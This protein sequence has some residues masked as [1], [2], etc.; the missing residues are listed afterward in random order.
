MMIGANS[1]RSQTSC[2]EP[3]AGLDRFYSY[4]QSFSQGAEA[5]Q[6]GHYP[7]LTSRAF[8]DPDCF[9]AVRALENGYD[10]VRSELLALGCQAFH[11][12]MER[13]GRTGSWEVLHLFERGRKNDENCGL[14]PSTVR[15]I[16]SH[17]TV[18]TV[19]GLAYV[20]KMAPGTHVA[21]HC[22]PTNLRLRCHLGIQVPQGDCAIRVE[23][24]ISGWHEGKCIVFDDSLEHESWNHTA[25][26]RIVLI[27]DL[28]H[29]DLTPE[30]IALL[31]GL[32]NYSSAQAES[33][34]R[35]WIANTRARNA[36]RVNYD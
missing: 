19:A 29:P 33:L 16:E 3:Q 31:Q 21:A 27:V 11:S 10:E 2:L 6:I 4:L 35:Y 22:G 36:R 7:G 13:V 18:R 9:S 17:S 32:H 30:E 26:T 20:S 28:W 5:G 24:E 15:L 23:R 34:T 12:E 1:L 14:C 25:E 8:H